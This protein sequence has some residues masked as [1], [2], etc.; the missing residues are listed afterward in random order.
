MNNARHLPDNSIHISLSF[1]A[2]TMSKKVQ[3]GAL[4]FIAFSLIN[5]LLSYLL[6]PTVTTNHRAGVIVVWTIMI[7]ELVG[8]LILFQRRRWIAVG[9]VIPFLFFLILPYVFLFKQ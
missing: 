7:V 9:G 8:M 5:V 3:E 1:T 4:G 6:T 2:M